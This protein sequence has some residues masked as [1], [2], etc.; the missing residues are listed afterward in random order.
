MSRLFGSLALTLVLAALLV[1]CTQAA[2]AP[3]T[4]PPAKAAEPAKAAAPAAA[5]TKAAEPAKATAQPTAAPAKKVS[6][7]EKGKTITI[8]VP[9]A[10][11][12]G[13]DITTRLIASGIEKDLGVPVQVVNKPGASSQVGATEALSA[14]PDGYTLVFSGAP[15]MMAPYLDPDRKATYGRKDFLQ[16]ANVNWDP[17]IVAVKSDSPHKTLK[18]V[19]DAAR[20]NPGKLNMAS[21]G[22]GSEI[23]M[24]IYLLQKAANVKFNIVQLEGTAGVNTA[25]AGGHVDVS[26]QGTAAIVPLLKAGSVRLLGVMDKEENKLLPGV[27]TV[28]SQGYKIYWSIT[29]GFS[30]PAGTPRE[31]VDTIAGAIQRFMATDEFKKRNDELLVTAKFMGPDEYYRY[32]D[33]VEA[34]A[35]PVFQQIMDE[36]KK[37]G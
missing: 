22:I 37:K 17:M 24:A 33:E 31:I 8:I 34:I 18:D 35:R 19:I 20:A 26:I 25:L 23:H 10:A 11:G 27:P 30:A 14:K 5:P 12:G 32:W 28:E 1:A 7:P 2:P 3:P 21:S 36:A 9:F 15:T 13:G 6:F 29:R 4:Q 16:I